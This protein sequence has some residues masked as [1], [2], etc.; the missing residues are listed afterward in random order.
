MLNVHWYKSKADTWLKLNSFNLSTCS[1]DGVYVI[2]HGGDIPKTV[3]VGQGAPVA[4]RLASH[5]DD[6]R[7][8]KYKSSELYV[9][10]VEV[11]TKGQRNSIERYLADS[12]SPLVGEVHP[13]VAPVAVKLPWAA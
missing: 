2:W 6:A 7:I 9:T 5:R 3:Y 4:D 11:T 13:D 10:W 1:E 8:Q 12:L